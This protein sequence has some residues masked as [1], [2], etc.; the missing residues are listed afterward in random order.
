MPF[1][2]RELGASSFLYAQKGHAMAEEKKTT[3]KK[4][5]TKKAETKKTKAESF[6]TRVVGGILN[7]RQEPNLKA[8]IVTQLQDGEIVEA[9]EENDGWLKIADGWVMGRFTERIEK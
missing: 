4:A 3:K 1:V 9:L 5:T 8:G 7:V 6:K 2:M